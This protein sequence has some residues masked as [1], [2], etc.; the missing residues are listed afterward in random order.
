VPASKAKQGKRPRTVMFRKGD[1]LGKIAHRYKVKGGANAI[2]KLNHIRDPKKIKPG[3]K[4]KL[5]Q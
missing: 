1:T 4:L 2:K 5:P 3:T